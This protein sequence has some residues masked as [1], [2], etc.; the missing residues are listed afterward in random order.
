M[1]TGN[2]YACY[3]LLKECKKR[4]TTP[5][6]IAIFNRYYADYLKKK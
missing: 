6:K 4:L 3:A 1:I 5:I 2:N